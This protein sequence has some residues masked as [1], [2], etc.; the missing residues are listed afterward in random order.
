M[1]AEPIILFRKSEAPQD[2]SEKLIKKNEK[3][4]H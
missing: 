3:K 2:I 1:H 4:L